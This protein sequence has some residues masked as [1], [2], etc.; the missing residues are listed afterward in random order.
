M[1]ILG[2]LG[3]LQIIWKRCGP[4]R[5]HNSVTADWSGTDSIKSPSHLGRVL[6]NL[7]AEESELDKWFL[8]WQQPGKVSSCFKGLSGMWQ[9]ST[10]CRMEQQKSLSCWP[11]RCWVEAEQPSPCSLELL[12]SPS[13]LTEPE[14]LEVVFALI[15]CS[16]ALIPC[17]L[18]GQSTTK[19]N[20]SRHHSCSNDSQYFNAF[21]LWVHKCSLHQF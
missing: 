21:N 5:Q 18:P 6:N 8:C 3:D 19:K 16:T 20:E 4:L 1:N 15:S 9:G 17:L 2:L 11:M 12:S 14:L 13:E 7:I 10:S